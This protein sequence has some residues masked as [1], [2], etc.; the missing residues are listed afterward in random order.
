MDKKQKQPERGD[1]Q[2]GPLVS[3]KDGNMARQ[4]V[5]RYL[6]GYQ[7]FATHLRLFG[8]GG[9]VDHVWGRYFKTATE[10]REDFLDRLKANW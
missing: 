10:A 7:P 1:L 4:V 9:E 8:P 3:D 6:G 2:E 5:L